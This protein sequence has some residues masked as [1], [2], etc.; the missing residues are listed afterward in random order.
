MGDTTGLFRKTY[1][2]LKVSKL[3]ESV[4]MQG[5]QLGGCCV[6]WVPLGSPL[7]GKRDIAWSWCPSLQ[8]EFH[9]AA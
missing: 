2:S 8:D 3:E 9:K 1:S 5:G 4:W 7:A 6:R